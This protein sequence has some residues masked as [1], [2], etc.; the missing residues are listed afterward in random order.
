MQ[1]NFFDLYKFKHGRNKFF[2]GKKV[3]DVKSMFMN[4]LI[5]PNLGP[6]SL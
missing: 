6:N 4:A 2:E 1:S 3:G 5:D